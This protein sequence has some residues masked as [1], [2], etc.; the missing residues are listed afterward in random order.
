MRWSGRGSA[1]PSPHAAAAR[2]RRRP[3]LACLPESFVAQYLED[4]RLV[5]VLDSLCKPFSGFFLYH[6]GR[7]HT[8]PALRALIDFLKAGG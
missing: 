3:D 8:P 7:R 6:P 2:P 1:G 4:G 5:R